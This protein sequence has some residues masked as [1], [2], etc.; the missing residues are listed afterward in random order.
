MYPEDHPTHACEKFITIE[1]DWT[2]D[3]DGNPIDCTDPTNPWR[4]TI[5]K[6]FDMVVDFPT[7]YVGKKEGEAYNA[8]WDPNLTL[9]RCKFSVGKQAQYNIEIRRK[10]RDTINAWHEVE[11]DYPYLTEETFVQPVFMRNIDIDM[12]LICSDPRGGILYSQQWEGD[13]NPKWYKYV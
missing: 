6:R 1:G 3:C 4:I 11:F 9:H 10:S 12:R 2:T 7:V 8:K 13:Y 5:G